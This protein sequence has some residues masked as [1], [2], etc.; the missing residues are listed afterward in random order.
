MWADEFGHGLPMTTR[1][2]LAKPGTYRDMHDRATVIDA[3]R[4][5]ELAAS[6]QPGTAKA[7]LVIGHPADGDAAHGWLDSL[8]VD[9]Q[10]HLWGTVS[11]VTP[12]LAAAVKAGHYRNVSISWWPKGHTSSPLP[13]TD[14]IR[15][16]GVLGAQVPAIPGLTPLS[17]SASDDGI[18]TVELSAQRWGWEAVKT[19]FRNLRDR[20]I[21]REGKETADRD[22]PAYL[23]DEL[24]DAAEAE[25]HPSFA[26]KPE[27]PMS[28]KNATKT[29]PVD[30][31]AQKAELDQRATDLA[32]RE[33]K[34]DRLDDEAAKQQSVSFAAGLVEKGLLAP[35]GKD[36]VADIHRRLGKSDEPV[37]FSNGTTQ[38]ALDAFEALFKGATPIVN[39][40][41]VSDPDRSSNEDPPGKD[42]ASL[43][44]R[45]R[46]L[47]AEDPAMSFSAAVRQ[48]EKEADAA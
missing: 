28:T 22:Y 9:D 40:A 48:A 18:V 7:P 1:I 24:D 10:G 23:F 4:I 11:D 31:A 13:A 33:A 6:Y 5:N 27:Q 17:F 36:V 35:A 38:P 26:A 37:S 30:L 42:T 14:T 47:Q 19:I 20:T 45:A 12:E 44:S 43:T 32:A 39:L 25:L 8:D 2:H 16:V 46:K 34:Q 3:A 29:P 41:A 21:E 15:H